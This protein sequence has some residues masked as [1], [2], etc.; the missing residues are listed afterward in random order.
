MMRSFS[1]EEGPDDPGDGHCPGDIPAKLEPGRQELVRFDSDRCEFEA[2]TTLGEPDA[3]LWNSQKEILE[4]RRRAVDYF[5]RHNYALMQ[6]LVSIRK[7]QP[8]LKI[9]PSGSPSSR[10]VLLICDVAGF[11]PSKINITWRKRSPACSPRTSS[12]TGTGPSR[13]RCSWRPSRSAETSTPARWN[14]P[15]SRSPSPSSG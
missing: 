13:W 11:W 12:G 9:T 15:A 7:I 4:D 10:H 5:C 2:V 14:T 3:Q 1:S 6:S 8:K